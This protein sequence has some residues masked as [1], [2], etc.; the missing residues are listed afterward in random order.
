MKNDSQADAVIRKTAT[1]I[2]IKNAPFGAFFDS[3]QGFLKRN[4][5]FYSFLM[6]CPLPLGK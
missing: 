5:H 6:L 2:H 1:L 3:F 4:D